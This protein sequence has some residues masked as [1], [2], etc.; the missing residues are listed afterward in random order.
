M[1]SCTICKC[2]MSNGFRLEQ[3]EGFDKEVEKVLVSFY[4]NHPARKRV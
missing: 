3:D 1:N 4:G 2:I